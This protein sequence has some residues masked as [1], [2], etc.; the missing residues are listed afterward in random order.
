MPAPDYTRNGSNFLKAQ[1]EMERII[2]EAGLD[3]Y[4]DEVIEAF[5]FAFGHHTL[6]SAEDYMRMLQVFRSFATNFSNSQ[7]SYSDDLL[8]K[9]LHDKFAFAHSAT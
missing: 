2:A 1:L 8:P 4:S 6:D 5:C 7:T 3:E 9:S